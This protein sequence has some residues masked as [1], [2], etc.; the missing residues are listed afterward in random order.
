[1]SEREQPMPF[2][3]AFNRRDLMI[4]AASLAG[5]GLWPGLSNAQTTFHSF[6]HGDFDIT[7]LSAGLT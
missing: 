6:R 5:A 4:G 1:M 7:V 2:R 3:F